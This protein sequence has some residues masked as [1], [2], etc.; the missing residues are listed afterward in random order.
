M[1]M[2]DINF[3]EFFNEAYQNGCE[4]IHP[5]RAL[6][7][8]CGKYLLRGLPTEMVQKFLEKLVRTAEQCQEGRAHH[9]LNAAFLPGNGSANRSYGS[10]KAHNVLM[11]G[12]D[13]RE[14]LVNT[15][16]ITPP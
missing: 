10:F 15:E 6:E 1:L 13:D 2:D 12:A 5:Q 3:E 14:V 16:K 7:F 11:I 4:W 8:L 9:A